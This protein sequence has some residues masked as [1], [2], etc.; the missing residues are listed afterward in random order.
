M[1]FQPYRRRPRPTRISIYRATQLALPV[2]WGNEADRTEKIF[3]ANELDKFE[4]LYYTMSQSETMS[5]I[6]KAAVLRHM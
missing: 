1:L 5:T 3:A 4:I 6:R 2:C